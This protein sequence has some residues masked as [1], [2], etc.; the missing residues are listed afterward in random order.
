MFGVLLARRPSTSTVVRLASPLLPT[1]AIVP[2][3][4]LPRERTI[5]NARV[6]S[7]PPL[8]RAT[9]RAI[10]RSRLRR[11]S[12][13]AHPAELAVAVPSS[14]SSPA[15]SSSHRMVL[16]AGKFTP[17]A[18]NRRSVVAAVVVAS[19]TVVTVARSKSFPL[20][21]N[22]APSRLVS[23]SRANAS[24]CGSYPSVKYAESPRPR[25]RSI[26]PFARRELATR[27]ALIASKP[28]ARPD[29]HGVARAM[30]APR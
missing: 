14:S 4:I 22:R 5:S 25:A 28:V 17:L 13:G 20:R 18:E 27:P 10:A 1:N 8:T 3:S 24:P 6:S 16:D 2:G 11:R 26:E 19:R 21:S 12:A 15:P 23:L 30:R 29:R 9:A 7:S